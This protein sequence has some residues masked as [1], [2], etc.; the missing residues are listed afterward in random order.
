MYDLVIKDGHVVDPHSGINHVCDVAFQDGNIAAVEPEISTESARSIISAQGKLV[1]P[2]L[3]DIHTHIYWGG[4]S[5][6]VDPCGVCSKSGT[7]TF[8]DAGS[9]GAGNFP[10]FRQFIAEPTTLNVFAFLNISFAGIFGFTAEEVVGECNDLRLLN[11]KE[12]EKTVAANRDMI[13]GIKVRVGAE[14]GGAS[15]VKPL[16]LAREV[17]DRLELPVMAHLDMPPPSLG[18]V[19]A[20]MQP[21]DILT[22]CY[23]PEPNC[24]VST[25][26]EVEE[27]IISAKKR[28]ILFDVGHGMGSFSFTVAKKMI[29]LGLYPDTISSDIHHW[30]VDGPAHDVLHTASK[31]L[32]LGMPLDQVISRITCAPAN[33]IR[34]PGLGRLS[35]GCRADAVILEEEHGEFVFTD[36]LNHQM[37]SDR[38]LRPHT[39]VLNGK[40]RSDQSCDHRLKYSQ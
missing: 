31:F 11:I 21:G 1:T 19:M 13:V 39:I 20:L 23:R 22:H 26:G 6:G 9:S 28:G 37:T 8:V 2:G 27:E 35:P 40:V 5:L 30:S 7:T 16:R 18:E 10:G 12:C 34:R 25:E 24:I 36:A 4:T 15:G 3:V 29:K 14:A 38:R 32:L 17:A 33:A